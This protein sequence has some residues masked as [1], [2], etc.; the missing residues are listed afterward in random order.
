[1]G[2]QELVKLHL[3]A[4]TRP[5]ARLLLQD[6]N[7]VLALSFLDLPTTG[8]GP[9]DARQ[10]SSIS[11]ALPGSWSR[12]RARNPITTRPLSALPRGWHG[13]LGQGGESA[14]GRVWSRVG[15]PP[16]RATGP[17]RPAAAWT[18]G[19]RQARG[20]V[21]MS[22]FVRSPE[23]IG[24]MTR[25]PVAPPARMCRAELATFVRVTRVE[26]RVCAWPTRSSWMMSR[27][28]RSRPCTRAFP[29]VRSRQ[30]GGRRSTR[31]G[32]SS[33]GTTVFEPTATTSSSTTTPCC[34][35]R[36]WR[37][38]SASRSAGPSSPEDEIVFTQTPAGR[39]PGRCTSARPISWPRQRR[40]RRMVPAHG[41][42]LAGVSWEIY[43][44]PGDD[45]AT[46]EV[47]VFYLLG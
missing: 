43:G 24:A 21:S 34:P 38:T 26:T 6:A 35:G 12:T 8:I 18:R 32:P 40:N 9:Y 23:E 22:A 10:T 37:S 47:Q 19:P 46:F 39:S 25:S 45:P 13:G 7:R 36:R 17:D 27:R 33:A 1:M 14:L 4:A 11:A 30:P 31:S 20:S 41:R 5:P 42:S 16:S 3:G 15:R 29:S 44:D 2:D 28:V